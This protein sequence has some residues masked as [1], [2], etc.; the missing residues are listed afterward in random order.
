MTNEKNEMSDRLSS[1]EAQHQTALSEIENDWSQ[2]FDTSTSELRATIRRLQD[3]NDEKLFEKSAQHNKEKHQ[4]EQS[5]Q[6]KVNELFESQHIVNEMK[7]EMEMLRE[8]LES[9]EKQREQSR[10]FP[11]EESD[12]MLSESYQKLLAEHQELQRSQESLQKKCNDMESRY[13]TKRG[14][15]ERLEVD[16]E[17]LQKEVSELRAQVKQGEAA[18]AAAAGSGAGGIDQEKI[19]ELMQN[20]YS[21]MGDLFPASAGGDSDDEEH[22]QHYTSQDVLKRCRKVLKQVTSPHRTLSSHSFLILFLSPGHG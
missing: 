21:R 14:E 9:A 19:N 2:K 10:A 8:A 1:L 22:V 16:H 18:L 3:E 17:E 20:I 11:I 13:L 12:P 4:L 5:L 7:R 15:H 6:E